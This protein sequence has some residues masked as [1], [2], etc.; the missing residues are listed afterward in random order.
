LNE[1][2]NNIKESE[3]DSNSDSKEENIV[4]IPF[5]IKQPSF[6]EQ[7]MYTQNKISIID[8]KPKENQITVLRRK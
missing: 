4:N 8:K 7:I 5:N 6:R 3:T 1:I 2:K